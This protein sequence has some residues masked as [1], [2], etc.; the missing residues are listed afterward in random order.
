MGRTITD[1]VV[2][3]EVTLIAYVVNQGDSGVIHGL[4]DIGRHI[5]ARGAIIR[6]VIGF[7]SRGEITQKYF[8]CN[9]HWYLVIRQGVNRSSVMIARML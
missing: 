6:K 1:L 7:L 9:L 8:L 3:S 2:Y 5:I 4:S